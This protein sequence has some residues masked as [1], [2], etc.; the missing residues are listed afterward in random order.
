MDESRPQKTALPLQL[1]SLWLSSVSAILPGERSSEKP[2]LFSGFPLATARPAS[3]PQGKPRAW[4]G[5]ALPAGSARGCGPGSR[6]EGARGIG[7]WFGAAGGGAR[8]SGVTSRNQAQE[9][10]APRAPGPRPLEPPSWRES[11]LGTV[12]VRRGGEGAVSG[13]DGASL[14]PRERSPALCRRP[15]QG[16]QMGEKA[17]LDAARKTDPRR[18]RSRLSARPLPPP[19]REEVSLRGGGGRALGCG[20]GPSGCRGGWERARARTESPRAGSVPR[21]RGRGGPP[22]G[23]AGSSGAGRVKGRG[24]AGSPGA[25]AAL[26]LHPHEGGR[27]RRVGSARRGQGHWSP[28]RIPRGS[29][30]GPG[31]SGAQRLLPEVNAGGSLGAADHPVG[32]AARV[33]V[34]PRLCP[35]CSCLPDPP[36]SLSASVCFSRLLCVCCV[37]MMCVMCVWYVWC[38]RLS[39]MCVWVCGL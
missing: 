36:H 12:C 1:C 2:E 11:L 22:G 35:A 21:A 26:R 15:D 10:P 7:G 30:A 37:C 29:G 6:A 38:V 5:P 18:R 24:G 25:S 16:C 19:P 39:A 20:P 14:P 31:P 32:P 23:G 17:V 3:S 4:P 27:P 13:E 8:V 9:V 33:L 34:G 28:S